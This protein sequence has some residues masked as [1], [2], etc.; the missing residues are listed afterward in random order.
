M[1]L[2]GAI[3]GASFLFMRI[4]V[5][6][7]GPI[8]LIEVRVAFGGLFLLLVALAQGKQRDLLR[9]P[10]HMSFVGATNSALPYTL[11]AYGLQLLSAGFGS[12]INA[13]APFFGALVGVIFLKESLTTTKW[14]GSGG[15]I[16]RRVSLGGQQSQA[17]RQHARSCRL[18]GSRVFL[19]N[20]GPLHS[21]QTGGSQCACNCRVQSVSR[22]AHVTA[23]V[24]SVLARTNAGR[25]QLV[26]GGGSGHSMHR[27]GSAN[28]LSIARQDRR[29]ASDFCRLSHTVVWRAVGLAVSLRADHAIDRSRRHA[30]PR[31]TIP[32]HPSALI[33]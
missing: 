21:A 29:H 11:F 12:V 17:R 6:E 33:N 7:F 10:L 15:G 28:L 30:D 5:K 9:A 20:C 8:A 16:L 23:V 3:W 19:W 1:L 14:F 24:H 13:T 31:R 25:R 32:V 2:L 26:G 4:A 27:S 22:C 18:S